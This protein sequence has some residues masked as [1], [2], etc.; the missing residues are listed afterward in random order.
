MKSLA[1]DIIQNW[2]WKTVY[3]EVEPYVT[4]F[5]KVITINDTISNN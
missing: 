2:I 3:P 4:Y 1:L 5:F